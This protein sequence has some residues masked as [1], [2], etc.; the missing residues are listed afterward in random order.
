M[1]EIQLTL[2]IG[3]YAQQYYLKEKSSP[4]LTENVRQYKSFLP[5]YLP[6]IHPS[7]RNR[8]WQRKN[9]WFELDVVPELQ[10]RVQKILA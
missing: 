9:P 3:Q 2:L 10:N 4:T 8:I 5:Y 7:P 6:L 1:K